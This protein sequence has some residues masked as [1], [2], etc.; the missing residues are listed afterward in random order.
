M[1]NNYFTQLRELGSTDNVE[2]LDGRDK[3]F[4]F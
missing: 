1:E 2:E 3:F 4:L